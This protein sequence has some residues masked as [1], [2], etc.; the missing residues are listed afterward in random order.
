MSAIMN[1]EYLAFHTFSCFFFI[2]I[3]CKTEICILGHRKRNGKNWVQN[4]L[5]RLLLN[6]C[7]TNPYHPTFM[8]TPLPSTNTFFSQYRSSNRTCWAGRRFLPSLLPNTPPFSFLL[9]QMRQRPRGLLYKQQLKGLPLIRCQGQKRALPVLAMIQY[10]LILL[11]SWI[12]RNQSTDRKE[13]MKK[14]TTRGE[15]K[16]RDSFGEGRR[17]EKRKESEYWDIDGERDEKKSRK[18]NNS[19]GDL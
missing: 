19:A 13:H 4:C 11:C 6:E 5:L 8:N 9:L 15:G 1:N 10:L 14:E 7:T 17:I 3:L 12:K 18:I 16:R 2:C